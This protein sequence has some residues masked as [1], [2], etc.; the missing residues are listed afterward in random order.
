[1]ASRDPAQ[2]HPELRARLAWMA[3]EWTRRHPDAPEPFLTC[4]HRPRE[5]QTE[6]VRTG[7]SRALPGQSLHNFR[8][9]LAFDVAFRQ[10]DGSVTWEFSWF[11]AWGELAEEA[12]LEWGGRWAGLVDGPHV[13]WPCT[14]R[15]AQAGRLPALPPLPGAEPAKVPAPEPG[16]RRLPLYSE[17]NVLLGEVT[18][19]DDRKAYLSDE[20]RE[21]L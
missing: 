8:P 4:T 17:R 5:E 16:P 15:D 18:I 21:A 2:L 7:R 20:L 13:Q 11:Q 14:W 3:V 1:M 6:L 19:V 12:G 9:A 10:P